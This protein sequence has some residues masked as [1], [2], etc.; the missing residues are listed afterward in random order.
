MNP[1][2]IIRL[3]NA[4][5]PL[6]FPAGSATPPVGIDGSSFPTLLPRWF[7][8]SRSLGSVNFKPLP[9]PGLRNFPLAW[10][11]DCS[12][13]MTQSWQEGRDFLKNTLH[14]SSWA[15]Y[16][17][18]TFA[19]WHRGVGLG[20][21]K[22]KREVNSRYYQI[23]SWSWPWWREK[24]RKKTPNSVLPLTKGGINRW[25]RD[26]EWKEKIRSGIV[27]GKKKDGHHYIWIWLC[28]RQGFGVENISWVQSPS[29][30]DKILGKIP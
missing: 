26:K 4:L 19:A 1:C 28:K 8:Q 29:S 27:P 5:N 3:G 18:K 13:P 6:K 7:S 16:P 14:V 21:Y 25:W 2:V 24:K 30:Q 12:L 20:I 10:R 9:F 17:W 11:Q 15:S 23:C 22:G